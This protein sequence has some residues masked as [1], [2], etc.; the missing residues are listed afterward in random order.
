MVGGS[1]VNTRTEPDFV[2]FLDGLLRTGAPAMRWRIIR[3]NLDG[4]VKSTDG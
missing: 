2:S 3:D 1:I 4:T